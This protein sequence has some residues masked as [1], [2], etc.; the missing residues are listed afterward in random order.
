MNIVSSITTYFS[1]SNYATHHLKEELKKGKDK[2]GIQ[3]TGATCF[4]SFSIH[5]RSISQC[6]HPMQRCLVLGVI[7][8]DMAAVSTLALHTVTKNALTWSG[9]TK[10][11]QK[12]ILPGPNSLRFQLDLHNM[13]TLLTPIAHGLETLEGQNTTCSD[14]FHIYIGIAINFVSMFSDSG[15]SPVTN[16]IHVSGD[17]DCL[18]HIHSQ[19]SLQILNANV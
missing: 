9:Q 19:H 16:L 10:A 17:N 14:V 13:N 8:F 5:A 15:E 3:V 2:R 11:L 6:L 18:L 4:S 7:K 12:Y 1:H